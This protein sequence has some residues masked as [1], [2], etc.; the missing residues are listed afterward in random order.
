MDR[1]PYGVY[2]LKLYDDA[3]NGFIKKSFGISKHPFDAHHPLIS[4]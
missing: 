3:G 2:V 4:K 1:L